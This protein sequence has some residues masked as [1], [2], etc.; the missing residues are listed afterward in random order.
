MHTAAE[1]E[2]ETA[3]EIMVDY[4]SKMKMNRRLKPLTPPICGGLCKTKLC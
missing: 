4:F 3:H 1:N 2:E